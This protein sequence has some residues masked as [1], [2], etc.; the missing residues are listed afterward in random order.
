VTEVARAAL[1]KLL[2]RSERAWTRLELTAQ[3][4]PP[5]G[6]TALAFTAASF[7]QY[8]HLPSNTAKE[9]THA[10]LRAAERAGAIEIEWDRM[11]GE[12]VQ[13]RAIRS[14]DGGA[15]ARHLALTPLWQSWADAR[16]ALEPSAARWPSVAR[17]LEAWRSGKKPRGLT[18]D[19][20]S[21]VLDAIRVIEAR[22]RPN[23]PAE[24]QMRRLSVQLFGESKRIE[25]LK[26]PLD[27]LVGNDDDG[28]EHI[29]EVLGSFGIVRNPQPVL[30]CGSVEVRLTEGS[31]LRLPAPYLG[32]PSKA[33]EAFRVEAPCAYILTV[34]NA[35]TFHELALGAAGAVR[36]IVL[37][38]PGVPGPSFRSLYRRLLDAAEASTPLFHWGDID[39]AGFRIAA[40]LAEEAKSLGRRLSL[41]CMDPTNV[42]DAP[43]WRE[44]LAAERSLMVRLAKQHGWTEEAQG[45]ASSHVAYEQEAL[46]PRLP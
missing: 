10:E 8:L 28:W 38:S 17:L 33:V 44:L 12:G 43:Q 42:G 5:D 9:E 40:L 46:T 29:D 13:I 11:A 23:A 27:Y 37:Q 30:M 45:L 35:T 39:G 6:A 18:P 1:E 22:E 36:G 34:E 15:L 25:A 31:A 21:D 19:R 4:Q 14:R 3:A 20:L 16:T 26:A 24:V 2:E 32:L 41:F 7:P